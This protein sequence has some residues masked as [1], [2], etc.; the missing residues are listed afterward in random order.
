MKE[1]ILKA[2]LISCWVRIFHFWQFWINF[3]RYYLWHWKFF[4]VELFIFALYL[5]KNPF[6][7]IRQYCEEHPEKEPCVY[8]ETEFSSLEKILDDFG[9]SRDLAIAD[10]GSG[11]GR[12]CFWLRLV[13]GQKRVLGIEQFT[14]FV[15]HARKIQNNFHVSNLAFQNE[16]WDK[17]SFEG[18]DVIYFY[19]S[20]LEDE[21]IMSLGKKLESLPKGTKIITTSYWF[22]ELLPNAFILEAKTTARFI[23]GKANVY[24]QSVC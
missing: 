21:T 5:F 13:R 19:G 11:R 12:V 3:F 15:E 1:T 18:V 17:A 7:M 2:F 10:L 14:P 9:I 20:A 4:M 23:W 6:G 8:G 16:S 22:G 24:L